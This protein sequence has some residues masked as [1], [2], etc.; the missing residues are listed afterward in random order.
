MICTL[1]ESAEPRLRGVSTRTARCFGVWSGDSEGPILLLPGQ[2]L[3]ALGLPDDLNTPVSVLDLI[4]SSP[5]VI[6]PVVEVDTM[7]SAVAG[8]EDLAITGARIA[9]FSMLTGRLR[10]CYRLAHLAECSSA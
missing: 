10:M 9:D 7:C 8:F 1:E 4:N 6:S 3:V 2:L 5:V